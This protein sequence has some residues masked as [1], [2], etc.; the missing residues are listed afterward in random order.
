MTRQLDNNGT[1]KLKVSEAF[2]EEVWSQAESFDS[3]F[4]RIHDS[5]GKTIDITPDEARF[6]LGY[7]DDVAI[8]DGLEWPWRGRVMRIWKAVWQQIEAQGVTV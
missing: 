6:I 4:C 7:K 5:G 2:A 3:V 1:V 8:W